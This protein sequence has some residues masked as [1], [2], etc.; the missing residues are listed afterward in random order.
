MGPQ[1]TLEEGRTFFIHQMSL[2]GVCTHDSII[3]N[4]KHCHELAVTYFEMVLCMPKSTK[5]WNYFLLG[6]KLATFWTNSPFYA[7]WKWKLGLYLTAEF[8]VSVVAWRPIS[9]CKIW[10]SF[11][12]AG[13]FSFV[14]AT[15]YVEERP[16]VCCWCVKR[17]LYGLRWSSSWS[18]I[19]IVACCC[20]GLQKKI[21]KKQLDLGRFIFKTSRLIVFRIAG[22]SVCLSRALIKWL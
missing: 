16:T 6:L 3:E 14:A 21:I 13:Q 10:D 11:F 17:T 9:T 2:G 20:M 19:T 15:A 5:G 12:A 8:D 1:K 7:L 18:S 22:K 4:I